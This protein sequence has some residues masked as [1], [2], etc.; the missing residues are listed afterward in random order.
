LSRKHLVVLAILGILVMILSVLGCQSYKAPTYK[1]PDGGAAGED[2]QEVDID[3]SDIEETPEETTDEAPEEVVEEAPD[4]DVKERTPVVQPAASV[5]TTT[6]P[7]YVPVSEEE[8][9]AEEGSEFTKA[10]YKPLTEENLPTLTVTEGQLVK[11]NLKVSDPDGDK[12][13]Y[14]FT[15]PLNSE[16]SWQT[17]SG[18]AGVYYPEVSVSDGKA[19]VVK[20]L[21][22]VVE[23]KNN[24]PVLS[25]IADMTVNEGDTVVLNPKA[26]DADGDK[27]TFTYS[28]WMNSNT[29]D[30]GYSEEG[31]HTVTVSV[32]DGISVVSQDVKVT[33]KDV[34][35]PP[36]VEVEF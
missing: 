34:N 7:K 27:L 20:K 17:R 32:T 8:A 33:V 5:K 9:P 31:E 23:P 19:T 26:S 13:S 11:L 36:E 22:I 4:V 16:G 21:K 25:F 10:P 35:R 15:A 2:V 18:D 3:V 14:E 12:L 28:G 24:K 6:T 29:K 30:V 1:S